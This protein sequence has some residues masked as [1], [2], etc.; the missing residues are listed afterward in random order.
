MRASELAS[1]LYWKLTQVYETLLPAFCRAVVPVDCVRPRVTHLPAPGNQYEMF[2]H[3]T[4]L[5]GTWA[6][7]WLF[8][9]TWVFFAVVPAI[10]P[11]VVLFFLM[12]GGLVGE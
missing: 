7:V 3:T 4:V 9:G 11:L 6:V 2:G 1:E 8:L 10:L 12:L 5:F